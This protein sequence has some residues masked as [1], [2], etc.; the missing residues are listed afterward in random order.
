MPAQP[1]SPEANTAP[2]TPASLRKSRRSMAIAALLEWLQGAR[3]APL[4]VY[5]RFSNSFVGQSFTIRAM[6]EA[7]LVSTGVV[8]LAEMGDKTQLL[9]LM[10]AARYRRPVP[11][12]AGIALATLANHALAAAFGAWIAQA[13][14]EQMLRWGLAASFFAMA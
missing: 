14:G 2:P 12:V 4:A 5:S 1:A 13:V 9:A 10:L 7:F 3:P 6:L 8:A 11:I